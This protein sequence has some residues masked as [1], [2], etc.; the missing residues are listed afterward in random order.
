MYASLKDLNQS[1]EVF[2]FFIIYYKKHLKKK[3]SFLVIK[4]NERDI[5]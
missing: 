5:I 2:L 4:R 3:L 1:K